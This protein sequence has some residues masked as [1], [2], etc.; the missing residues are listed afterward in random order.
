MP[1]R[2]RRKL[3]TAYSFDEFSLVDVGAQEGATAPL[4]KAADAA[5]GNEVDEQTAKA[6]RA[7]NQRLKAQLSKRTPAA[8]PPLTGDPIEA[9]AREAVAIAKAAGRPV[10]FAAAYA[11]ELDTASDAE[12]EA[13][14]AA[15]P[16]PLPAAPVRKASPAEAELDKLVAGFHKA[17]RRAGRPLT[18]EA[19]YA[20]VLSTPEGGELFAQ[21]PVPVA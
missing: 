20:E 9:R 5:G 6:L 12:I 17:A 21:I 7:E 14:Y 8:D 11:A 13:A 2:R 15:P 16:D 10:S 3:L 18:L 4:E 1:R 19:A